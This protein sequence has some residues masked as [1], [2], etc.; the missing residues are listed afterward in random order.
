MI[1]K[2]KHLNICVI[3]NSMITC[4]KNPDNPQEIHKSEKVVT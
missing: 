1:Y 2:T 4:E 3:T